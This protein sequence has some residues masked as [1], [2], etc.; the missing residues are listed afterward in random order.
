MKVQMTEHYQDARITLILGDVVTVN[1][2]LG[3]WLI[4]NGKAQ[5]L[6]EPVKEVKPEPKLEK[7]RK[8]ET[9]NVFVND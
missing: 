2:E 1:D 7:R 5:R 4:D 9:P 6:P 3:Q 8:D